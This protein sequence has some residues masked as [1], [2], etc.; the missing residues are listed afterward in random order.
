MLQELLRCFSPQHVGMIM[1]CLPPPQLLK[2]KL[3]LKAVVGVAMELAQQA[4]TTTT[5][6]TMLPPTPPL[7]PPLPPISN[8]SVSLASPIAHKY[9]H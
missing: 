4:T 2:R 7:M 3:K 1:L 5:T 8:S 9:T 6:T